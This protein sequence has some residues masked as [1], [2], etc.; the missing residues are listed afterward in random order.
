MCA[1]APRPAETE[2]LGR[3]DS[4]GH[5]TLHLLRGGSTGQLLAGRAPGLPA[6]GAACLPAL[7]RPLMPKWMHLARLP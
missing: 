4:S 2:G 1:Q 6:N 5:G 3:Q 7:G